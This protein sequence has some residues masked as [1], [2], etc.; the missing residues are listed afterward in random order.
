[1]DPPYEGTN[2]LNQATTGLI[3]VHGSEAGRCVRLVDTGADAV[4]RRSFGPGGIEAA[5]GRM[6]R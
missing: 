6:D 5:G 2:P 3:S 4:E 1:V